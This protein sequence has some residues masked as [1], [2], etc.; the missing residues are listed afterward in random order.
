MT[1][2][3]EI[4]S[5]FSND[6]GDDFNVSDD[7]VGIV[8][9]ALENKSND[10]QLRQRLVTLHAADFANLLEQ[11]DGEDRLRLIDWIWPN[12]DPEILVYLRLSVR[13]AVLDYAIAVRA[14]S[15]PDRA[16]AD[17]SRIFRRAIDPARGGGVTAILDGWQRH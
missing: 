2:G 10:E 6:A 8:A 15:R 4:K 7:L 3:A 14:I 13:K 16:G 5:A 9:E 11:L 12:L 1:D 17:L